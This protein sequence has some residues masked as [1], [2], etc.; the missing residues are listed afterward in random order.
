MHHQ[1]PRLVLR[2][3]TRPVDDECLSSRVEVALTEGRRVDCVEELSELS[4]ADL[5]DP[6][7][8][9]ESVPSGRRRLRWR[10]LSS[11]RE[12]FP[13]L[14]IAGIVLDDSLSLRK[15]CAHA[16]RAWSCA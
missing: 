2:Q 9:G 7:A 13:E 1:S 12:S 8:L 15:C 10:H 11:T 3:I 16:M 4:D 14:T 6:A 5:Y